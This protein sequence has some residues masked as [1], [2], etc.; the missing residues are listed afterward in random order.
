LLS[1]GADVVCLQETKARSE[2]LSEALKSPDGYCS[3]WHSARKRGYSGV[4]TY[5][6]KGL[7]PERVSNLG[8]RKFDNEGRVQVLDLKAFALVN[9]YYPNSQPERAR[10][11]YKLDFCRAIVRLGN[12]LREAGKP[13]IV[14]GDFNIAHKEIDL[15]RPKENV[16]NPGFYPEERRA[17]DRLLRAGY[18]D[19]FRYFTPDPGHYTWW[20]YRTNARARNIGWR[21]DYHVTD[22]VLTPR[23]REARIHPEVPGSDH[24]PVSINID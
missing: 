10:I 17:M 18:V 16:D 13:M 15:A 4:A 21:L 24:C 8:L 7:E 6:R 14:C 12:E 23:L 9:A 1:S 11:R 3:V 5:L 2:D 19:C 20:S 22:E